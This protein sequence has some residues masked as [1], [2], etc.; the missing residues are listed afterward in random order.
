MG[1]RRE[2]GDGPVLRWTVVLAGEGLEVQLGDG[3]A[4]AQLEPLGG[5]GVQLPDQADP[6]GTR[7]DPGGAAGA[8]AGDLG[9][10]HAHRIP[11][12]VADQPFE[13]RLG[14]T[15][16]CRRR[17]RVPVDVGDQPQEERLGGER[18]ELAVL[19]VRRRAGGESVALPFPEGASQLEDG[20]AGDAAALV[21]REH[22]TETGKQAH[23]QVGHLVAQRVEHAHRLAVLAET[24]QPAGDLGPE[25]D[26]GE[27]FVE[28]RPDT[29]V[30]HPVIH[31][32]LGGQLADLGAV[33]GQGAR[34]AR[35]AKPA[36]HLLGDVLRDA[37]VTPE[38][39]GMDGEP[40]PRLLHREAEVGQGA[41]RLVDVDRIA[42]QTS[43]PLGGHLDGLQGRQRRG[44]LV[45]RVPQHMTTR[46]GG[47]QRGGPP[48]GERCQVVGQPLVVEG[49][50]VGPDGVAAGGRPNRGRL[51]VGRLQEH[52]V[53]G[54]A[55]GRRGTADDPGQ[56]D[57]DPTGGDDHVLGVEGAGRPVQALEALAGAGSPHRQGD[58]AAPAIQGGDTLDVE[59]VK[60]MAELMGH[61]VGD[62]HQPADRAEPDGTQ[63]PLEPIRGLP[64][65][66][67]LDHHRGEA[68]AAH[69]VLDAHAGALARRGRGEESRR[70]GGGGFAEGF[71]EG[72]GQL[73]RDPDVAEAIGPVG[74]HLDVQDDVQGDDLVDGLARR[75]PLQD[76]QPGGVLADPQ[77]DGREQHPGG[78]VLAAEHRPDPER[79]GEARK[80]RARRGVRDQV[81]DLHVGCTGDQAD[82]LAV[83]DIDV[84]EADSASRLGDGGQIQH[85][86]HNG[87]VGGALDAVDLGAGVDQ[88]TDQLIDG[89]VEIRVF[90]EPFQGDLHPWPTSRTSFS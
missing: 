83:A 3:D 67:P 63:P 20:G 25:E 65:H 69:R 17:G 62:V 10:L 72:G 79:F 42:E 86:G 26:V 77:L 39:R 22:L 30:A 78:A 34:Q 7:M 80:D 40:V 29:D 75:A 23:P 43:E 6:A 74:G 50:G 61:V 84:G 46:D 1:D 52:R 13:E 15:Q 18:G 85:P 16:G 41:G 66:H 9:R 71:A 88:E 24:G 68:V 37:D 53:G 44:M 76:E 60:G 35:V 36:A 90:P 31:G 38:V 55:D 51:P 82:R 59:G 54:A 28:S 12:Q 33:T 73:A 57:R 27:H 4:S 56:A 5:A 87:A 49:G 48:Q 64:R 45:D 8:K 19:A 58:R 11:A 2:P 47:D 14:V 81:P 32:G 70:D 21:Q 89:S